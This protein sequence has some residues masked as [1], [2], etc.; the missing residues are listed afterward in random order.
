MNSGHGRDRDDRSVV[1]SSRS[2]RCAFQWAEKKAVSGTT[3]W[4]NRVSQGSVYAV[5]YDRSGRLLASTA[6]NHGEQRLVLT[7]HGEPV[8]S[9]AF[10]SAGRLL[11]SGGHDRT[12]RLWEL[13]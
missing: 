4:T 5:A 6:T 11:A 1:I 2:A 13:A 12:I 3:R 8:H 9:V 7:G 10:H